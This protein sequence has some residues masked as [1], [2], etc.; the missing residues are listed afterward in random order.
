MDTS[1]FWDRSADSI[2]VI[3]FFA[4]IATFVGIVGWQCIYWLRAG[5]WL[6]VPLSVVFDYFGIDLDDVYSPKNWIG[7]AK[8]AQWVL[9]LPLSATGPAILMLSAHGWKSFVSSGVAPV[10]DPLTK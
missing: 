9:N 8:V 5:E 10:R 4:S 3:V 6:P 2:F 7:L 1:D